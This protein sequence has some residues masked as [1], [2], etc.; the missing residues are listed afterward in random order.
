MMYM[1][2]QLVNSSS[3]AHLA[4]VV[5]LQRQFNKDESENKQEISP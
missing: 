4:S 3:T 1:H 5:H 2:L